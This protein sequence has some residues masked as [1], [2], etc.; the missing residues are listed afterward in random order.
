[1]HALAS[2]HCQTWGLAKPNVQ[3]VE[4]PKLRLLEDC[5]G[6]E[7]DTN[8]MLTDKE[9]DVN[10]KVKKAFCQPGNVSFCPPI[11]WVGEL[12]KVRK[13]FVVTRKPDN[14]GDKTYTDV[15]HLRKDFE[16]GELHPGDLKPSLGKKINAFLE[17]VRGP[18]KDSDV[19]K[20]A[21]KELDNFAAAQKKAQKKK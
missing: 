20:K 6:L 10:K 5:D 8:I 4:T 11:A 12:L 7:V 9:I 17:K 13:E 18:L 15:E 2:E 14:G 19:A 1:M 16:S 3:I 21:Q